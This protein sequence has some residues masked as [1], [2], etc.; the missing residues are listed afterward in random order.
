MAETTAETVR[1]ADGHD[2]RA[3]ERFYHSDYGGTTR[4]HLCDGV[5]VGDV[6]HGIPFMVRSG[7]EM[8]RAERCYSDALRCAL[9]EEAS[10]ASMVSIHREYVERHE[11]R[12]D[13]ARASRQHIEALRL[14]AI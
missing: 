7:A 2:L 10:A 1:I 6:I 4:M 12:L 13:K 11:A 3:G 5:F 9:N 8:F 14:D